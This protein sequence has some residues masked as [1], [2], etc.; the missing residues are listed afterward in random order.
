M[1]VILLYI[2]RLLDVLRPVNR[3]GRGVMGEGKRG[4]GRLA[5][6]P[7]TERCDT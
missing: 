7:K 4:D 6:V 1:S 3:D 5:K 2:D